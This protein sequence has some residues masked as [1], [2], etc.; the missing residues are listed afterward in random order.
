MGE[1]SDYPVA[2]APDG[3]HDSRGGGPRESGPGEDEVL[4]AAD[5]RFAGLVDI[6]GGRRLFLECRGAGSPTVILEAGY[7][8]NAE[9]WN[10]D[11][12][13]PDAPHQ[14]VFPGIAE[15]TRVCAYDRP[16]TLLDFDRRGRGDPGPMPRTAAAAVADLHALLNAAD[17]PGPY[18]LVGHSYG[19]VLARLYAA[20]YPD[21]VVGLV[22]VDASH[23]DQNRRYLAVLTPE[24]QAAFT[25]LEGVLPAELANDATLEL[26]DFAASSTQMREAASATPLPTL[27]LVVL[28]RGRPFA[29]DPEEEWA[30]I[31]TAGRDA[32]ER[33]SQ[34]MQEDLA[35]LTTDAR[36]VVARRSGHFVQSEEPE[37]VIEA[38]R[39]VVSAVRDSLT[40]GR[41]PR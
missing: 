16:G 32:L 33:E 19:G 40:W 27:P 41:Q 12:V 10:V 20:T 35:S 6:G 4:S 5:G 38:V 13:Q 24:E 14:M 21:E 26:F 25:R 37:L 29:A 17:V 30:G 3:H 39:A 28:A 8:N 22:L 2:R 7:R 11:V 23:E 36:L 9:I 18:V 31:S 34:L 1:C 15:F